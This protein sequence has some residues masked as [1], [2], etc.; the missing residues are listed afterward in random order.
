MRLTSARMYCQG[1]AYLPEM[2]ECVASCR[3][4]FHE[5][6]EDKNHSV[7][8]SLPSVALPRRLVSSR[9]S[10]FVGTREPWMD[11][12]AWVRYR[13]AQARVRGIFHEQERTSIFMFSEKKVLEERNERYR[14]DATD[15]IGC[16]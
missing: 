3:S 9:P 8:D 2:Y 12:A 15:F 11:A 1:E 6:T 14:R 16:K 10:S 7:V 5:E 13:L 4:A